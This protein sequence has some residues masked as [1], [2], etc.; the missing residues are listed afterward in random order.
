MGYNGEKK[1]DNCGTFCQG[2]KA[3]DG[4]I[5]CADCYKKLWG[6]YPWE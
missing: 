4:K 1:C 3:P 5:L 6:K 2:Y